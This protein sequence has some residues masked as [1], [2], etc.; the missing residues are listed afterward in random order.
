[1]EKYQKIIQDYLIE[2]LHID[3]NNNNN[4]NINNINTKNQISQ[5]FTEPQSPQ[6]QQEHNEAEN[7]YTFEQ[8][9]NLINLKLNNI[10][11][12]PY[13]IEN[14]EYKHK[15]LVE[16]LVITFEMTNE[17]KE[18]FK[19]V[20][21][22]Y[23]EAK[24]IFLNEKLN[25]EEKTNQIKTILNPFEFEQYKKSNFNFF[26]KIPPKSRV[27]KG[28]LEYL[29]E[30]YSQFSLVSMGYPLQF[31]KTSICKNNN[32]IP[33]LFTISKY[34]R[35]FSTFQILRNIIKNNDL[36][37]AMYFNSI[38]ILNKSVFKDENN[39]SY[40]CEFYKRNKKKQNKLCKII[41]PEPNYIDKHSVICFEGKENEP[42]D[43][44]FEYS[45]QD[46]NDT[47]VTFRNKYRNM[48]N[49]EFGERNDKKNKDDQLADSND[50]DN[51]YT[52]IKKWPIQVRIPSLK[53][54]L[55]GVV[56]ELILMDK[57]YLDKFLNSLPIEIIEGFI[58][59]CKDDKT[60]L[61]FYCT[62]VLIEKVLNSK[63]LNNNVQ[64]PRI[65]Q[66]IKL[67]NDHDSYFAFMY[68]KSISQD[69][70][71]LQY[72]QDYLINIYNNLDLFKYKKWPYD[73]Q[74][75]LKSEENMDSLVGKPSVVCKEK[76]IELFNKESHNRFNESFNWNNTLMVGGFV[77]MC[78]T[79]SVELFK[80]TDID[81]YFFS[82]SESEM[83]ERLNSFINHL[84][85]IGDWDNYSMSKTI[86][87]SIVLS[88]HYPYKHIKFHLE[89][90]VNKNHILVCSDVNS[91]SVAFDGENV[92]SL[93]TSMESLNYKCNFLSRSSW[94][95]NGDIRYQGR[96]VKYLNRGYSMVSSDL[97]HLK[98]D[99]FDPHNNHSGLSLLLSCQ[100]NNE[101]TQF[102]KSSILPL[103]F[104][105]EI[106]KNNFEKLIG[107]H[108]LISRYQTI[109]EEYLGMIKNHP[110][111]YPRNRKYTSLSSNMFPFL[112]VQPRYWYKIHFSNGQIYLFRYA[113]IQ[114]SN[115]TDTPSN[116][117]NSLSIN[118]NNNN[119]NCSNPY[120][121]NIPYGKALETQ[122]VF[123]VSFVCTI[124]AMVCSLVILVL[125]LINIKVYSKHNLYLVNAIS[126]MIAVIMLCFNLFS[127]LYPVLNFR[128]SFDK[129]CH[130]FGNCIDSSN[131]SFIGDDK[132]ASFQPWYSWFFNCISICFVF[133]GIILFF[134]KNKK[135]KY[136]KYQL[137]V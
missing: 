59:S 19:Q 4:N 125:Q 71:H 1:M 12:S 31:L 119:N 111:H 96:L 114:I 54:I 134:I 85:E 132:N 79:D 101:V 76:F 130:I 87:G 58:K 97:K 53:N 51:Y 108:M 117:N 94:M 60:P 47:L 32:R 9:D 43:R 33:H 136:K 64:L 23:L 81:I 13:S 92:Y 16:D 63:V 88:K 113:N 75:V 56:R 107:D 135:D 26:G 61:G 86:A 25:L 110:N 8:K 45:S 41:I 77:T 89:N 65:D 39:T 20:K 109:T 74:F 34:D 124:V 103:P 105:P 15:I 27:D 72:N 55:Y 120:I 37:L 104:G 128:S 90:Y 22:R 116:Q 2:E 131:D 49:K 126:K 69:I 68:E 102:I 99:E 121:D 40:S 91:S 137:L 17:E 118:N 50:N 46:L 18:Y 7:T 122:D 24:Q 38:C 66:L 21:S 52:E 5:E 73:D 112:N 93:Y 123:F 42:V 44:R 84:K 30:N 129:E 35:S 98:D 62:M 82:L 80:E 106:N 57:N 48:P 70:F 11:N 100:K 14:E 28:S 36:F 115:L 67:A 127:T 83:L 95:L 29:S 10:N 133:C 78:L 6:T 3:I